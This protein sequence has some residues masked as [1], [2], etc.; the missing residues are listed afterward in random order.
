MKNENKQHMNKDQYGRYLKNHQY[1]FPIEEETSKI[2]KEH[3]L[4]S[5]FERKIDK[6]FRS[7]LSNLSSGNDAPE[8]DF[9]QALEQLDILLD[10]NKKIR[11]NARTH[12]KRLKAI[13]KHHN[14]K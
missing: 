10:E 4:S 5:D 14:K 8:E 3:S 7:L 6:R 13:K 9:Y 12:Q 11:N 1:D 2:S